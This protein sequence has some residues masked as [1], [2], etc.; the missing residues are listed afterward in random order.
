MFG[1]SQRLSGHALLRRLRETRQHSRG[2]WT[3]GLPGALRALFRPARAARE[4][5]GY[6]PGLLSDE[7]RKSIERM[8]LHQRGAGANT[9]RK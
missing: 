4:R 7:P 1:F 8:V 3:A 6:S 2:V 9:V 5:H